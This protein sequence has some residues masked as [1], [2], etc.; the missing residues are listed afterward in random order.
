M[1]SVHGVSLGREFGSLG[2]FS[3]LSSGYEFRGVCSGHEFRA[4]SWC[5]FGP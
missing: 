5:V 2:L 3:S 4:C 1:V